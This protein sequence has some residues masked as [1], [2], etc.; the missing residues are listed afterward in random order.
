MVKLLLSLF[1]RDQLL[2]VVGF[3]VVVL[4][5]FVRFLL[6]LVDQVENLRH[7]EISWTVDDRGARTGG[8]SAA[9]RIVLC[10]RNAGMVDIIC[11]YVRQARA[12]MPH[13]SSTRCLNSLAPFGH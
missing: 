5:V 12:G 6:V 7:A 1:G 2:L 10:S 11:V 9:V 8:W 13:L 4:I 3:F